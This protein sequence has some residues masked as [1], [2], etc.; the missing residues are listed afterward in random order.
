MYSR[1]RPDSGQDTMVEERNTC[2]IRVLTAI[3]AVLS[4]HF[5]QRCPNSDKHRQYAD[6]CALTSK[7]GHFVHELNSL[8]LWPILKCLEEGTIDGVIRSTADFTNYTMN[9]HVYERTGYYCDSARIDCKVRLQ[10]AVRGV[11]TDQLGLC[12]NCV[13]KATHR[14]QDKN[15]HARFPELCKLLRD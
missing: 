3:E 13:K 11:P 9:N 4:S 14:S 15:C 8:E 7:I 6:L 5:N 1:L 12:L 2:M 10:S